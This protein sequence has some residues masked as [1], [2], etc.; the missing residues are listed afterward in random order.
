MVLGVPLA[1]EQWAAVG[2]CCDGPH[3][4]SIQPV[5]GD[6][7]LAQ[8]FAIDFNKLDAEN[9]FSAGDP[10]LNESY[11]TYGQPVYAVANATVVKAIDDYADQVPGRTEGITLENADG[12]Y[13]V[14]DLGDGH[15]AFYAHLKP[16][17]LLVEAGET[18][19][20]GQQIGEAGNT[21]SSDG[22]HL[23]FHVMDGPSVL[24]SDGLPYVFAEFDVTG[25]MPPLSEAATYYQAQEPV[26]LDASSAGE[27]QFELPLSGEVVAF[28]EPPVN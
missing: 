17:S 13:I 21:G 11:P 27:R 28:P 10:A 18:V 5:N 9:R 15:Y 16:G 19:T 3:R 8:R 1:G 25:H 22:P 26:P 4:R 14:L 7:Y 12:N 23:H 24:A 6:L 20:R 2:S